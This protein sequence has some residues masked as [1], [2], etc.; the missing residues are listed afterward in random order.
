MAKK[1]LKSSEPGLI[2]IKCL[3]P[4]CTTIHRIPV[5]LDYSALV[6]EEGELEIK[7]MPDP[8]ISAFTDH[9]AFEHGMF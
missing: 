3:S 7:I 6:N 5:N 4:E 8:D 9:L 2:R 1:E